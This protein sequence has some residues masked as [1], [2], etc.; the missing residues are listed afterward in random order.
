MH[1]YTHTYTH[2]YIHTHIHTCKHVIHTYTYLVS[3]NPHQPQAQSTGRPLVLL[4][5]LAL[6]DIWYFLVSYAKIL[7]NHRRNPQGGRVQTEEVA[8]GDYARSPLQPCRVKEQKSSIGQRQPPAIQSHQVLVH[9][10][11]RADFRPA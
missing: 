1:T 2:T 7:T 3:K 11:C 8:R 9:V 5:E 4:G 6:T 10:V